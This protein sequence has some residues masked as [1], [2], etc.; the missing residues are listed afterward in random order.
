MVRSQRPLHI[1]WWEEYHIEQQGGKVGNRAYQ[2]T[3]KRD[4]NGKLSNTRIY[5]KPLITKT[6]FKYPEHERFPFGV[7]SVLPLGATEPGGKQI[8]AVDYTG[9]NAWKNEVY[10]KPM[11]EE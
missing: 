1:A 6:T 3:F 2:Y 11:N 9:K 7:A 10:E 4:E 8:E 5:S